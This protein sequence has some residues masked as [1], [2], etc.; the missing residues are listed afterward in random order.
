MGIGKAGKVS[1]RMS[2]G[3][4]PREGPC[5]NRRGSREH[6]AGRGKD[7]EGTKRE[8]CTWRRGWDVLGKSEGKRGRENFTERRMDIGKY[9]EC[10]GNRHK[11]IGGG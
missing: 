8:W 11:G 9:F 3:E 1:G 4:G 5:C 2:G 10:R 7:Y 6:P